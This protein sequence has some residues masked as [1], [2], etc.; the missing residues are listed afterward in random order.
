MVRSECSQG[1]RSLLQAREA[2][3][4]EAA[5]KVVQLDRDVTNQMKDMKHKACTTSPH[6]IINNKNAEER[7][8]IIER[9][10][11]LIR[12]MAGGLRASVAR[13]SER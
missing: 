10:R 11:E 4:K 5:N 13:A 1:A 2:E 9:L 12:L 7:V 3:A 6:D 8:S